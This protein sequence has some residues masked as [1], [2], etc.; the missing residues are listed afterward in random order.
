MT[1][2]NKKIVN[3][4]ERMDIFAQTKNL[5]KIFIFVT[6]LDILDACQFF[7]IFQKLSDFHEILFR[8]FY[9]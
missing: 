6:F 2:R 7:S 5:A 4:D 8:A 3:A 9:D 1:H